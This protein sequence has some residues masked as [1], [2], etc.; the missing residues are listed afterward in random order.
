MLLYRFFS[1]NAYQQLEIADDSMAS[2][3]EFKKVKINSS[4]DEKKRKSTIL[5]KV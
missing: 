2:L 3:I 1:W 4:L 5:G